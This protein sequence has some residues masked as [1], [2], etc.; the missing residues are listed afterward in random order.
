MNGSD[1]SLGVLSVNWRLVI[2][3]TYA[4]TQLHSDHQ[5]SKQT[6]LFCLYYDVIQLNHLRLLCTFAYF[7]A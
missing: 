7:Q 5:V 6:L 1:G 3:N 2:I 4:L